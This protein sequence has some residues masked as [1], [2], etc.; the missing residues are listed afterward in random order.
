MWCCSMDA[1]PVLNGSVVIKVVW[2]AVDRSCFPF[3]YLVILPLVPC[4]VFARKSDLI[5]L[6]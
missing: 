5:A 1:S 6:F 4:L 2:E 3:Q